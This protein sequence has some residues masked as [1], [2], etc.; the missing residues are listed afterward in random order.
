MGIEFELKYTATADSQAAIARNV[1]SGYRTVRMET[2][3]YDTPAGDLSRR[4]YT[5]RRR[6]ENGVS[7][8]TVKTPAGDLGR[9]E[10]ETECPAIEDAIEPL[11][12]LGAPK[13]LLLLTM[14]GVTPICGARFTRRCCT[15]ELEG[16]AVEL[17]LDSG[18]LTG[19]SREMPLCEVEVELKAGSRDAA[20][21]FAESL[22]GTY[23]LTPQ[24]KSKFRR[25]LDLYKGE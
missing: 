13:N 21:A 25:A 22:A 11:C 16:C 1:G 14:N 5:L 10:W 24:H 6:L 12:L 18:V 15:L 9:G 8:C 4:H 20:I 17:A 2:T 23:G 3:Y 19:G 7:V